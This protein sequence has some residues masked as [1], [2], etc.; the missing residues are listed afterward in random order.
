MLLLSMCNILK[1]SR[2]F[3]CQV[4]FLGFSVPGGQK[5]LLGCGLLGDLYSDWHYIMKTQIL[6]PMLKAIAEQGF[7]KM[8][9]TMAKNELLL[10]TVT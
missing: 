4:D 9:Q 7:P 5:R 10:T 6:I 1:L 8:G 2:L 3:V